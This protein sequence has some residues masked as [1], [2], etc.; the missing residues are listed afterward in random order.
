MIGDTLKSWHSRVMRVSNVCM[1][2]EGCVRNLVFFTATC[3]PR[4]HGSGLPLPRGNGGFLHDHILGLSQIEMI[5]PSR[6]PLSP[7]SHNPSGEGGGVNETKERDSLFLHSRRKKQG[8]YI[9]GEPGPPSSPSS[10][11]PASWYLSS[12]SLLLVLMHPILVS[13][14]NSKTA[15]VDFSFNSHLIER[16]LGC[17]HPCAPPMPFHI[18]LICGSHTLHSVSKR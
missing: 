14:N 7:S 9:A 18:L 17:S 16:A 2:P 12:G 10:P 6:A 3:G 1:L 13:F 4:G 5:D 15:S 8:N 11:E